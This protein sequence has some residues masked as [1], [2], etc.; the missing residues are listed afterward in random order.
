M[1]QLEIIREL[2]N[3]LSQVSQILKKN[4]TGKIEWHIDGQLKRK[5][6]LKK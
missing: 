6:T 4:R 5:T 1:L 3:M 2:A